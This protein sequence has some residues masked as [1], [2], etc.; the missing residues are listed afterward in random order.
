TIVSSISLLSI[1]R[2]SHY[3]LFPY[4]TLFRSRLNLSLDALDAFV[5][6]EMNG[7]GTNPQIVL[8]N[9]EL[10]KELGFQIKVNMVV[11]KGV[12]EHEILPMATHFKERGITLR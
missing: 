1:S 11:K 5:F 9:I 8:K 4:T 6:G 10:A 12:N 7:R 3:T 2:P